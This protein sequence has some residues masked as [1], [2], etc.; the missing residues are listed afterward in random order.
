MLSCARDSYSRT[1]FL[2]TGFCWDVIAFQ[3][4][5]RAMIVAAIEITTAALRFTASSR[6]SE[7]MNISPGFRARASPENWDCNGKEGL[8]QS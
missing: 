7:N 1:A 2:L 3:R 4:Y 5:C 8:L 6:V